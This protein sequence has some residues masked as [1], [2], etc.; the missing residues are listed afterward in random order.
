MSLFSILPRVKHELC[1]VAEDRVVAA[2]LAANLVLGDAP[3]RRCR[4]G[5]TRPVSGSRADRRPGSGAHSKESG[6]SMQTGD[7][8]RASCA[9]L[10]GRVGSRARV[11]SS[12]SLC[13]GSAS[14]CG[15]S[16]SSGLVGA[17][18]GAWAKEKPLPDVG[19]G[20][21]AWEAYACCS[22]GS[23]RDSSR[24]ASAISPPSTSART[25]YSSPLWRKATSD[26]SL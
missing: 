5:Q 24:S 20:R 25:S 1:G 2:S 16:R 26:S 11:R 15:H 6:S 18:G 14:S 19:Q 8:L 13:G 4:A 3:R 22:R 23:S 17:Y 7:K 9:G 12:S 21:E 10:G